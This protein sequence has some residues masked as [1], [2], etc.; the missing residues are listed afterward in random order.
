MSVL[1]AAPA[2][3]PL[4]PAAVGAPQPWAQPLKAAAA[5]KTSQPVCSELL[6]R[7]SGQDRKQNLVSNLSWYL[8]TCPT[9]SKGRSHQNPFSLPRCWRDSEQVTLSPSASHQLAE[10]YRT[11]SL[12]QDSH[13]VRA[14]T[15]DTDS[16]L[17]I[18]LL[19]IKRNI[20]YSNHLLPIHLL[21][22]AHCLL[23]LSWTNYPRA[24]TSGPLCHLQI[25]QW[26]LQQNI[27]SYV[28][29]HPHDCT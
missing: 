14:P 9:F 13:S 12:G 26:L 1:R 3:S 11:N 23:G 24:V 25:E 15:P 6:M 17:C 10:L 29:Q 20:T 7:L 19:P 4:F 21:K 22:Y 18:H 28:V 16:L 5:C 2:L 27:K 8:K